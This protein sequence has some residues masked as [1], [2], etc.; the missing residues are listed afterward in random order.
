MSSHLFFDASLLFTFIRRDISI[1]FLPLP[2]PIY[3]LLL[4]TAHLLTWS[5]FRVDIILL[6]RLVLTVLAVKN[7]PNYWPYKGR[8]RKDKIGIS[9]I[10]RHSLLRRKS[11]YFMF[12]WS[13]FPVFPTPIYYVFP[14]AMSCQHVH[15][16]K[17]VEIIFWRSFNVGMK[18][19]STDEKV[20][21][22]QDFQDFQILSNQ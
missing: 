15:P 14:I 6:P 4:W 17:W 1:N 11:M 12:F 18:K 8:G 9:L 19:H 3:D 7:F 16:R 5:D 20:C 10:K 2:F 22:L 13:K 21:D